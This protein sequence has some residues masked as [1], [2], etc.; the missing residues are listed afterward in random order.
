MSN[1]AKRFTVLIIIFS[2]WGCS[3]DENLSTSIPSRAVN[4][5]INTIIEHN[6]N[7]PYYSKTYSNQGYGGV[8]VISYYD[9]NMNLTLAAFDL[10][11]P[12]EAEKNNIVELKGQTEVQCSK[13]KSI[14]NIS[15]GTGICKSGPSKERLRSYYISKDGSMY[16]IRN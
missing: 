14:Y 12:Y 2:I 5:D 1:I 11:C 10:S 15:S 6:F 9:P 16:R 7:N 4:I 13:C 3:K 8:I